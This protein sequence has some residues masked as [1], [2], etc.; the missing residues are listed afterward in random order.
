M[1]LMVK[2]DINIIAVMVSCTISL[3]S[4]KDIIVLRN[5]LKEK[6]HQIFHINFSS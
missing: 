1:G 2:Y 3:I 4:Q 5:T 6:F